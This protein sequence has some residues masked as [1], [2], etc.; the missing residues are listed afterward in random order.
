MLSPVL[1]KLINPLC[2]LGKCY[3]SCGLHG[4]WDAE[5]VLGSLP[6]K[7]WSPAPLGAGTGLCESGSA[8]PSHIPGDWHGVDDGFI[9]PLVLG[10]H[11][12]VQPDPN[13]PTSV[14]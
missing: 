11:V 10:I 2:S 6:G 12:P 5:Q 3:H 9:S 13:I 1:V 14:E 7:A 4:S 8:G